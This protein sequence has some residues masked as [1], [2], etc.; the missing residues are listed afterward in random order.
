M[1]WTFHGD[2]DVRDPTN[3][4]DDRQR[5]RQS[6]SRFLTIERYLKTLNF[7]GCAAWIAFGLAVLAAFFS[8]TLALFFIAVI[9]IIGLTSGSIA[10]AAINRWYRR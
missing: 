3:Q 7:L 6:M 8:R 2:P 10:A 1:A 5:Y 4:S 9:A